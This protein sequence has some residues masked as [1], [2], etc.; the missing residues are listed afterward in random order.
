M[1]KCGINIERN[2]D[3]CMRK[4]GQFLCAMKWS[5]EKEEEDEEEKGKGKGD[6]THERNQ[7][8]CMQ[9]CGINIERNQDLCMQKCGINIRA[10]KTFVCRKH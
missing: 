5:P 1:Q 2:Q 9:K 4:C 3:L 10:I 7:D 6:C 8:L